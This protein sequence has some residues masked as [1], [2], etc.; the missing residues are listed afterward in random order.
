[1][2][3][4]ANGHIAVIASVLLSAGGGLWYLSGRMATMEAKIDRA[5]SLEERQVK[6][7]EVMAEL[8]TDLS[9]LTVKVKNLEGKH[10]G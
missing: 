10:N 8:K 4:G 9:V 2:K 1:M 7:L 3:G 5:I 6:A